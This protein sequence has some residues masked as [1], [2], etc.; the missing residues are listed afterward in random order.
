MECDYQ[1]VTGACYLLLL[2]SFVVFI[3]QVWYKF[4]KK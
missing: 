3:R 1:Y 4:V 2:Q